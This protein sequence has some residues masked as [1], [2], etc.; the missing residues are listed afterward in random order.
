M[1]IL[2]TGSNGLVGKSLQSLLKDK[3]NNYIF[4]TSKDC[5]L[6]NLEDL[7]K[8]FKIY[9]PNIVIHLASKV[10]GLYGNINNNYIFLMDNIK[11]NLNILECCEKYKIKRLINILSTC[12]FPN[13]NIKYPLT[14]NQILNGKPHDSNSGYAYSKRFLYIGS[15]LLSNYSNIEIINLI[16]TNLYGKNDNYNLENSHVI[17]GLI[18]KI[19]LSKMNNTELIIKGSG[20]AKRQFLYVDDLSKIILELLFKKLESKFYSLVVS[21]PIDNEITIKDLITILSKKFK[22]INKIKYDMQYSDGQLVKTSDC[23]ELLSLLPDF[24][25]TLLET[26]LEQ[27]INYFIENYN[28]VR[29]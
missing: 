6:R 16:P 25:F 12:I 3:S 28:E 27:T 20:L 7:N 1:N 5:D 22:V 21:P 15:E 18:H 17:P 26:G 11:I 10:A 8:I 13:D 4:L 19:Y 29:K 14:S 2:I 24:K 9:Q 23:N